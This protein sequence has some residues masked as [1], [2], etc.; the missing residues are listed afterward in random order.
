M[1]QAQEKIVG[2][3]RLLPTMKFADTRLGLTQDE[4]IV[5]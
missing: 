4:A 5:R 3:R 2:V 1:A